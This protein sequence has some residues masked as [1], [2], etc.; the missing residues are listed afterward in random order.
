M[1]KNSSRSRAGLPHA[2]GQSFQTLDEYLSHLRKM[3]AQD[4]PYYEKIGDNKYQLITGRGT[5]LRPPEIFTREMLL[6]KY[7]FDE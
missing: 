3:G 1:E 6:K 4:R 5:N 7:G 2:Q